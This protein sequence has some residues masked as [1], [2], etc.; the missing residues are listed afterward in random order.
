MTSYSGWIR[1]PTFCSISFWIFNRCDIFLCTEL[2]SL[3]DD[4]QTISWHKVTIQHLDF[5]LNICWI[6]SRDRRS[7]LVSWLI[8]I[9]CSKCNHTSKGII[10]KSCRTEIK[11]KIVFNSIFYYKS[12]KRICCT[13]Y[14]KLEECCSIIG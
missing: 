13:R 7:N 11:L 8:W 10:C 1:I 9:L 6:S 14:N 2:S 4:S 12:G 5:P 3:E